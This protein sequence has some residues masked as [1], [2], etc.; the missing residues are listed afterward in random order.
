MT[1]KD[2]VYMIRERRTKTLSIVL[3]NCEFPLSQ[4]QQE[5]L[6]RIARLSD[7][8]LMFDDKW[9][10]NSSRV[11]KLKF[12]C[13]HD[14][15]G[16][17]DVGKTSSESLMKIFEYTLT[18]PEFS[19]FLNYSIIDCCQLGLLSDDIV[20]TWNAY[21]ANP[22]I[23]DPIFK[24]RRLTPTELSEIYKTPEVD[25]VSK[26]N[27]FIKF[28]LK[29]WN[30][31]TNLKKKELNCENAYNTHIIDSWFVLFK[32]NL[33]SK[34]VAFLKEEKNKQYIDSFKKTNPLYFFASLFIKLGDIKF[35]N[36]SIENVIIENN[37]IS[38]K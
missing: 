14:C 27:S 13:L 26:N 38:R 12:T 30:G 32:T 37:K 7:T 2:E 15:I 36:L 9:A 3:M 33:V 34:F 25:L 20:K 21:R 35:E 19:N 4:K 17:L 23:I 8:F 29:Y 16:W 18:I 31:I 6:D 1:E 22:H 11:N 28:I 24:L 10:K 5:G